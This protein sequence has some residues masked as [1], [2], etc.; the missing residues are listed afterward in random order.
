MTTVTFIYFSPT[1]GGGV[2]P[3]TLLP[4]HVLNGRRRVLIKDMTREIGNVANIFFFSSS[5]A[6]LMSSMS[7]EM[8]FLLS[9]YM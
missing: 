5:V 4:G 3:T 8:V 7:L 1:D 2:R 9:C 6:L